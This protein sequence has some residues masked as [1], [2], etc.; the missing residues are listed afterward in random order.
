METWSKRIEHRIELEHEND[1]EEEED[2]EEGSGIDSWDDEG[3]EGFELDDET[4]MDLGYAVS[5]TLKHK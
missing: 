3:E 4:L 5:N 2:Q 1:S